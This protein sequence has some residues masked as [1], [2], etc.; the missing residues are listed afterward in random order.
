MLAILYIVLALGGVAFIGVAAVTGLGDGNGGDGGHDGGHVSL[1]SPLTLAILFASIGAFGLITRYGLGV[2]ETA[3]ILLSVAGGL[4][5]AYAVGH[6]VLRLIAS[7]RGSS[8]IPAAAFVGAAGEVITGIPAG[9]VGEVALMVGSQRHTGPA[10]S[11]DGAA[12]AGGTA[13]RVVR[14]A[15]TTFIVTTD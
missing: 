12:I 9:G 10:R 7:S 5:T 14:L 8:A 1:F 2:G 15:G 4:V 6:S 13:V 3:S 11:A